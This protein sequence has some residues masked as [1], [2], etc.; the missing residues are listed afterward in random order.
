MSRIT[1]INPPGIKTFSSIQMQ[2]PNPPIGLAY[3]SGDRPW[4]LWQA[5]SA[6]ITGRE[7]TRLAK[8]FNDVLVVRTRWNRQFRK[9]EAARAR[10]GGVRPA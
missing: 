1:L 6:V 4:R 8:W 3:I 2:T 9:V 10:A 5:L 7:E